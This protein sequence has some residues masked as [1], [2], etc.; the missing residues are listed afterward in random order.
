MKTLEQLGVSPAPWSIEYDDTIDRVVNI[1]GAKKNIIVETDCGYY[2]PEL[3]DARLMSA[4]P[5]LYEALQSLVEYIDREC[6]PCG[7]NACELLA[8]AHN[9]LAKAAGESEVIK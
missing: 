2:P 9:A 1:L 8:A 6:I 5:E 3:P 7:E 4:A